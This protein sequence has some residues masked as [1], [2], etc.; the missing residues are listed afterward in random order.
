MKNEKEQKRSSVSKQRKVLIEEIQKLLNIRNVKPQT[1]Q[2]LPQIDGQ[3]A[4]DSKFFDQIDSTT[5]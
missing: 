5:Y 3:R 2:I 1:N 4:S